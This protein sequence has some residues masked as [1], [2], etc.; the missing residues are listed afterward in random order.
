ME[1]VL[2]YFKISNIL[3]LT[4]GGI[5]PYNGGKYVRTN[6]FKKYI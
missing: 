2:T 3:Y 5:P 6:L 4:W 1:G